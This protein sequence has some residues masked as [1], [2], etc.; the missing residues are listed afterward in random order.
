MID[1]YTGSGGHVLFACYALPI[2]HTC[3]LLNYVSWIFKIILKYFFQHLLQAEQK[4]IPL[5]LIEILPHVSMALCI[6]NLDQ[7]A[8]NANLLIFLFVSKCN[9]VHCSLTNWSS[10][11]VWGAN[12]IPHTCTKL[13]EI[14]FFY[15]QAVPPLEIAPSI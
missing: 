13:K 1:F 12:Y 2:K 14:I 6:K 8:K 15:H 11:T 3:C 7:L 10:D 9:H 5:T 4:Q